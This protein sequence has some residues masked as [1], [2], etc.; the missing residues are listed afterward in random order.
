MLELGNEGLELPQFL[1]RQRHFSSHSVELDTQKGQAPSRGH[2]FLLADGEAEVAQELQEGA[3]ST[4]TRYYQEVVQVDDDV[5]EASSPHH[6]SDG[7]CETVKDL[8]RDL[9]SKGKSGVEEIG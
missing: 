8:W 2:Q 9:C 7:L 4:L 5:V 6:A 3:V 1:R